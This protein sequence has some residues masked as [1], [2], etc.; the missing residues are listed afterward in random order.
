MKGLRWW[1]GVLTLLVVGLGAGVSSMLQGHNA[2]QLVDSYL[3]ENF[4]TF[5]GAIFPLEHTQILKW[6]LFALPHLFH[7]AP[8]I[9]SVL[10]VQAVLVTIGALL[11]MLYAI[12]RRMVVFGALCI[13]L[14]SV[15]LLVPIQAFDGGVTAPLGMAMLTGRNVEYIVYI[16]ALALLVKMPRLRSWYFA[17][18]T[19]LLSLL[20]ASDRLFLYFSFGGA[21]LLG[22]TALIAGHKTLQRLSGN[23]L[24]TSGLAW[25]LSLGLQAI[26]GHTLVRLVSFP[27][28]Y[29]HV[30]SLSGVQR[31]IGGSLQALSLNFGLTTRAGYASLPAFALNVLTVVLVIYAV[32]WTIRRLYGLRRGDAPL[33]RAWGFAAMLL[34]TSLAAVVGFACINQPYIQNA[35]YLTITV[36]GGFVVLAVWLRTVHIKVS[37]AKI[38]QLAVGSIACLVL[39]AI[40][41]TAHTNVL[42]GKDRLAQRNQAIAGTLQKHPVEYLVGNYWRAVPI[43]AASHDSRQAVSPLQ[44]CS[45]RTT[46]LTSETWRP[47]LR[48]HSFAYLLTSQA[49]SVPQQVCNKLTVVWLYGQ[50][51]SEVIISGPKSA[52]REVLLF[53]DN[54]AAGVRQP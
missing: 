34:S 50:P 48:R 10:T 22:L 14:T 3:F 42:R 6:P 5:H 8:L 35:R 33:P 23:W 30:S 54:G 52:P 24:A 32:Y 46:V 38:V 45:Q 36:F 1:P 12:G 15:L 9:Y 16:A 47:D 27:Q 29:E 17:G 19:L 7:F 44:G 41:V 40:A 28:H 11:Y 53:Y 18:S 4:R 13:L 39:A 21:V 51:T 31:G 25:L 37:T 26:M 2:D 20:F 43:R 49:L